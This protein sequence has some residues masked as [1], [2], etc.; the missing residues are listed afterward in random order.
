MESGVNK[1]ETKYFT[2]RQSWREWLEDNFDTKDDIWLEYPLKKTG[3]KRILY[4]DAVEEALC[5]GWID[6]TVKSLDEETTIQRFCKRRKNSSFS[7]PNIERLKRLFEN[8][9]IHN[10]IKD[11]VS[12]IIQ[13][14][15]VFP[16]DIIKRLKSDKGV[17]VN[18]QI[19][20]ESY[21][22]IR[23]AYIDSARKRRDEFEKRLNNFIDKTKENKQ[24]KGFGGIE[25]YY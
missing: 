17:W 20:S 19:F 1:M 10:S 15:F 11:E 7:Q 25:K 6:S 4:N 8:N 14:E 23:I 3:K 13:Q 22:R 21:K 5:F 24:I 9:L 2:E 18:F 12:K 16:E